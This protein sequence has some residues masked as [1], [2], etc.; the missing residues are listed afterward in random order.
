MVE[1][2]H[3]QF[4]NF[5]RPDETAADLFARCNHQPSRSGVATI[6]V[7]GGL[8]PR[9]I[10]EVV[11]PVASGKTEILTQVGQSRSFWSCAWCRLDAHPNTGCCTRH[12]ASTPGWLMRW[13]TDDRPGCPF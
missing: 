12:F 3:E 2:L 13:G 4:A 10:V 11:G 8:H 7:H 1:A 6:D 5:L 9:Q